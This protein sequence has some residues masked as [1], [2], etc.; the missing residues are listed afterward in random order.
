MLTTP[1]AFFPSSRTRSSASRSEAVP[2]CRLLV[3]PAEQ[4]PDVLPRD[5]L[6]AVV[7]VDHAAPALGA[8]LEHVDGRGGRGDPHRRHFLADERIDEGG[9]SGVELAH[10]GEEQWPVDG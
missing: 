2:A 1:S 3:E 6:D 5:V 4:R 10:D 8:V 7:E 9:F